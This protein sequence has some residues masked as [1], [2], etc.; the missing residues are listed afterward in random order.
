MNPAYRR[1][2]VRPWKSG[3]TK[4]WIGAE[5]VMVVGGLLFAE[6]GAEDY[7]I[8]AEGTPTLRALG[9]LMGAFA[10]YLA[11]VF[12]IGY[13]ISVIIAFRSYGGARRDY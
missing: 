13:F 7:E 6:L 4:A 8:M 2:L 12:L 3:L 5:L 1:A 10:I 11:I 9:G